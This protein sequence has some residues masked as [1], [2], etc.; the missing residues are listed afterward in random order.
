MVVMVLDGQ[1]QIVDTIGGP[2]CATLFSAI[3]SV[4]STDIDSSAA[5]SA[6]LSHGGSAYLAAN[7]AA[8]LTLFVIAPITFLGVSEGG[9]WTISYSTCPASGTSSGNTHAFANYSASI[10]LNGTVSGV[11]NS[12][13]TNCGSGY[14]NP[15][16][17][18]PEGAL[19]T[20]LSLASPSR[21]GT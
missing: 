2:N 15:G 4:S 17:A 9:G 18:L 6:A 19:H 7:P 20:T 5:L 8:N 10:A 13:T 21:R 11:D 1:A 14:V 3:G 16:A 12:T